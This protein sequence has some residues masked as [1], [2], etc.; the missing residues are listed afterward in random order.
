VEIVHD[1]T[2]A[3]VVRL[4]GELAVLASATGATELQVSLAHGR[5]HATAVAVA[6][7][8]PVSGRPTS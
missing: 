1:E 7:A 3:P 4:H 8:A 5:D 6:V 2:G